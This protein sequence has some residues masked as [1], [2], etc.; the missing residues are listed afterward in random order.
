[1]IKP[2]YPRLESRMIVASAT[3]PYPAFAQGILRRQPDC[4]FVDAVGKA[5]RADGEARKRPC[6]Q[7]FRPAIERLRV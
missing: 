3:F 5:D 6:K 2:R 7:S 1:M 4:G